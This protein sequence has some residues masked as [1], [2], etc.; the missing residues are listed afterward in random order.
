MDRSSSTGCQRGAIQALRRKAAG[1][2][3]VLELPLVA[4]SV[5]TDHGCCPT[6]AAEPDIPEEDG[7]QRSEV[8]FSGLQQMGYF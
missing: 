7:G 1:S 5:S 3:G 4:E 2:L 8:A 6:A